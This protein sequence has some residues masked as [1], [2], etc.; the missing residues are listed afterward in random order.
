MQKINNTM[1]KKKTSH[2]PA[3]IR[4]SG[5][6]AFHFGAAGCRCGSDSLQKVDPVEHE[7]NRS[8][9]KAFN[10]AYACI[11]YFIKPSAA[12]VSTNGHTPQFARIWI[13]WSRNF[14]TLSWL[15]KQMHKR[16]SVWT[17]ETEVIMGPERV[18]AWNGQQQDHSI[19]RSVNWFFKLKDA[20]TRLITWQL[21]A[22]AS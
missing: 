11:H 22:V 4:Y 16:H 9:Q 1:Y 12:P 8:F 14:H 13:W 20:W 19:K 21:C 17:T 7:R 5:I 2:Q 18:N 3:P 15:C 6:E 10:F